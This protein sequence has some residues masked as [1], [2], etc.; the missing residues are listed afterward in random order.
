[1]FTVPCNNYYLE[2]ICFFIITAA[3]QNVD[4]NFSLYTSGS[5]T[6]LVKD[7]TEE[8]DNMAKAKMYDAMVFEQDES[9][10]SDAVLF[11][12]HHITEGAG[13]KVGKS[14]FVFS[15]GYPSAPLR[16][17]KSI[18]FA[19]NSGVQTVAVGIGYF[20]EGISKYFPYFVLSSSPMSFPSALQ[21][22]YLGEPKLESLSEAV[23][24]VVAEKVI[25]DTKRLENMDEGWKIEIDKVYQ[26]EVERTRKELQ[27]STYNAYTT[28]NQLKIN[29]CFVLDTTGS[30]GSYIQMAKDKIKNIIDNIKSHINDHFGRATNLQVAFIGYKISGNNGHLDN[31]LFTDDTTRLQSFV[32]SQC[33]TGG[34]ST[35]GRE[36]KEDGMIKA[37]SFN[38]DGSVKFMVLISDISDRGKLG[39]INQTIQKIAE[40]N[41]YFLHV[42][43]NSSTNKERDGFQAAYKNSTG[44]KIKDTGFM[45]IDMKNISNDTN[46]L[47]EKIVEKVSTVIVAEFM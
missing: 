39:T 38:W 34:S 31:I 35:D 28:S 14:I 26:K 8:W 45:D 24:S 15:D 30:M 5:C 21:S 40:K 10:L 16:L 6:T 19:E 43:I 1:M 23:E 11:A 7:F 3:L 32:N 20:T 4:V 13:P 29:L 18:S 37:L 25:Y 46:I 36:D 9:N 42:T 2:Y 12:T 22:F 33:A 41:I 44:S 27:I 17:R 47:S